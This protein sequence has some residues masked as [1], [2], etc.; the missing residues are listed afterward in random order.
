MAGQNLPFP[1][2]VHVGL[3]TVQRYRAACDSTLI[4]NH[5]EHIEWYHIWTITDL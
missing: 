3:T 2:T 4:G 1:F 5:T